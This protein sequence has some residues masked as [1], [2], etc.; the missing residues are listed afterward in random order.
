MIYFII[1]ILLVWAVWYYNPYFDFNK[2]GILMWYDY[3]DP[4]T[5]LISRNFKWIYRKNK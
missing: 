2:D 1:F 5:K 4:N 3:R